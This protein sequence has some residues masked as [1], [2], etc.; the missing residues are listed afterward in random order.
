[1]RAGVALPTTTTINI[2][3]PI[4]WASSQ[5]RSIVGTTAHD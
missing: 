3:Q 5:M 4:S 1:M 2:A